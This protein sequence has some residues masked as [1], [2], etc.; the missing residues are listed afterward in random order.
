M[1]TPDDEICPLCCEVMEETDKLFEACPCGYPVCG[2]C[3]KRIREVGNGKCP[4]CRQ[5]Y[6][7]EGRFLTP[8]ER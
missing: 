8:A 2:F 1:A 3:W 6:K 4:G 7:G 5:D